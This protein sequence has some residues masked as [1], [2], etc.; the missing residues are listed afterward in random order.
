MNVDVRNR[1][2]PGGRVLR[3]MAA[4]AVALVASTLIASP[5]AAARTA[6][7]LQMNLCN[8][9]AADCYTGGLAAVG[10]AK[11]MI[12]HYHPNVVFIN[13]IC[14]GQEVDIAENNDYD[15]YSAWT[16][17][18][19]WNANAGTPVKCTNGADYGSA[20]LVDNNYV[21]MDDYGVYARQN[22]TSEQRAYGCARF[23]DFYGCVTHL[24]TDEPTALAQCNELTRQRLPAM[25]ALYGEPNVP[26]IVSGDLNL[27]YNTADPEN[28]QN[29]V[30]SGWTRKGDGDVQH[31]MV[32][33]GFTGM[34]ARTLPMIYTD[35]SALL[36]TVTAPW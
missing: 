3:L 9:G 22:S 36:V 8:G 4:A 34:S 32:S 24:S 31:V 21:Y 27:K 16:F 23:A 1:R 5:A 19:A 15:Y 33:S 28:V 13:E 35:H 30:P 2:G 11:M 7:I 20:I 10:E 26:S 25:K 12:E 29:C 18:A 17:A 6:T 14:R